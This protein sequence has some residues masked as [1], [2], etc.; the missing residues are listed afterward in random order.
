M[1]FYLFDDEKRNIHV[2]NISIAGN[3]AHVSIPVAKEFLNRVNKQYVNLFT[4]LQDTP[5]SEKHGYRIASTA[6]P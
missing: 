1:N 5:D 3:V 6:V 2:K 4:L